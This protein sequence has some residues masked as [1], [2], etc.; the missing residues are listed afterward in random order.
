VDTFGFGF[1]LG[2]DWQQHARQDGNDHQ[3]LNQGKTASVTIGCT[4][5]HSCSLCEYFGVIRIMG[6]QLC[7]E[8]KIYSTIS[9]QFPLRLSGV[10]RYAWNVYRKR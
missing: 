10:L 5:V 9:L 2:K 1:C 6:N 8:S 4:R 7:M 3:Q